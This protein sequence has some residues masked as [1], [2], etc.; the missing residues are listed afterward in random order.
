MASSGFRLSFLPGSG[1]T[2]DLLLLSPQ[3]DAR[4]SESFSPDTPTSSFPSLPPSLSS[5]ISQNSAQLPPPPPEF[6]C[7]AGKGGDSEVWGVSHACSLWEAQRPVSWRWLKSWMCAGQALVQ[8]S[9]V[10]ERLGLASLRL[11]PWSY[12]FSVFLRIPEI[13]VKRMFL[14]WML[15]L[16]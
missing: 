1:F 11:Q 10:D 16:Q 2:S 14:P 15:I 8:E 3:D 12:L 7:H 6:S 5:Q 4:G 9:C 13:W